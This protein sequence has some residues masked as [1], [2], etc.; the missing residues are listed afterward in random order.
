MIK[1]SYRIKEMAD[2]SYR[3]QVRQMLTWRDLGVVSG[4]VSVYRSELGFSVGDYDAALDIINRYSCQQEAERRAR[5]TVRVY[6]VF[7]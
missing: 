6:A 7:P 5:A 4:E 2:G 3:A 1:P